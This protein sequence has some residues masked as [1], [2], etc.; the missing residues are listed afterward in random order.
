[1]ASD[2]GI[3]F[4]ANDLRS[5]A[6]RESATEPR[7]ALEGEK[8]DL[9]TKHFLGEQMDAALGKQ[10]AHIGG[11]RARGLHVGG[12]QRKGILCRNNGPTPNDDVTARKHF[13]GHR[14]DSV[15]S[16]RDSVATTNTCADVKP[17]S[18]HPQNHLGVAPRYLSQR[19]GGEW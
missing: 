5:L 15:D 18:S 6:S 17:L 12:N 14:A 2:V 1:M 16:S 4:A 9:R 10:A 8:G 3:I 19:H 11:V 13:G 7:N